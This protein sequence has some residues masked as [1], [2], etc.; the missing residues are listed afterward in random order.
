MPNS[1]RYHFSQCFNVPALK[2]HK[3]CTNYD[4]QDHALMQV[5]SKREILH[6]SE[7][8]IVLTD[9]YRNKNKSVMRQKLVCLYPNQLSWTNTHL[10]GPNKYSQY[11]YRIVPESKMTCRLERASLQVEYSNRKRFNKKEIE[12]VAEKLRNEDS[13]A[14]KLLAAE[15][16]R[17]SR[18]K[19]I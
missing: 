1:I 6:I 2:A 14:W 12:L 13:A 11:L 18:M 5:N 17:E 7:N 16:E 8:T 15:M 3:W 4:P 10:T 19:L 9:K